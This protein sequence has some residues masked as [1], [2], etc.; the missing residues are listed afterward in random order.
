MKKKETDQK[1]EETDQKYWESPQKYWEISRNLKC[2]P[3]SLHFRVEITLGTGGIQISIQG[4]YNSTGG[5][6]ILPGG[7]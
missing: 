4:D 7:L 5:I 1:K 3:F 2:I 6:L